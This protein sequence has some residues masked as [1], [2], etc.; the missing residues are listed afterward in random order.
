[1]YHIAVEQ[2]TEVGASSG[3]ASVTVDGEVRS[4]RR[5]ALVDDRQEHQVVVIV[6]V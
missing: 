5:V 2:A 3:V 1:M 4:D 6:K